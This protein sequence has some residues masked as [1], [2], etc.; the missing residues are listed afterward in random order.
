[1]ELLWILLIMLSMSPFCSG[2]GPS[3]NVKIGGKLPI[4]G[5]VEAVCTAHGQKG[6]AVN[7]Y[8]VKPNKTK[9]DIIK[10]KDGLTEEMHTVERKIDELNSTF[11]KESVKLTIKYNVMSVLTYFKCKLKNAQFLICQGSYKCVADFS[12]PKR[13]VYMENVAI[14]NI[15]GAIRMPPRSIISKMTTESTTGKII[16]VQ[17]GGG[18]VPILRYKVMYKQRADHRLTF[19]QGPVVKSDSRNAVIADLKPYTEYNIYV[20]SVLPD[21]LEVSVGTGTNLIRSPMYRVQT[22]VDGPEI[23]PKNMKAERVGPTYIYLTWQLP[24]PASWNGP[25]DGLFVT[26]KRIKHGEL[27]ISGEKTVESTVTGH[28]TK[29]N[30]LN[31][32]PWSTYL[33]TACGFNQKKTGSQIMYGKTG[34]LTVDTHLAKPATPPLNLDQV[35]VDSNSATMKWEAPELSNANG[36]IDGYILR[37]TRRE[38]GYRRVDE[39][40]MEIKIPRNQSRNYTLKGLLP[41]STYHVVVIAY[42]MFNGRQLQSKPSHAL[43]VQTLESKP[44][45]PPREIVIE[46]TEAKS[47]LLSWQPPRAKEN[48]NGPIDGYIVIYKRTKLG[49]QVLD[50]VAKFEKIV[51]K[52]GNANFNLSGLLPWS[53]YDIQIAAFNLETKRKTIQIGKRL[54]SRFSEP[55]PVL[56]RVSEPEISSFQFKALRTSSTRASLSWKRPPLESANGPIGGYLVNYKR[57][58]SGDMKLS[59]KKLALQ[60]VVSGQRET[61]RLDQLKPWSTYKVEIISFNILNGKQLYSKANEQLIVRTEVDKPSKSPEISATV[62]TGVRFIEVRW[63]AL[64]RDDQNGPLDGYEVFYQRTSYGSKKI[65]DVKPKK[66][67]VPGS[68]TAYKLS[69]LVPWSTYNIWVLAYNLKNNEKLAS[70]VGKILV[71]KTRTGRPAV[72]PSSVEIPS[73][74][75]KSITISWKRPKDEEL[76]GELTGFLIRANGSA[77]TNT[78]SE[79]TKR[80]VVDVTSQVHNVSKDTTSFTLENLRPAT[81]YSLEVAA[82]T[83][84]GLGPYS[85]PVYKTT[86]E[87]APSAP[88]EPRVLSSDS[89]LPVRVAWKTPS[90]TNGKITAYVIELFKVGP[91]ETTTFLSSGPRTAY[92]VSNID[93]EY[94]YLFRVQAKT[95]RPGKW[96]EWTVLYVPDPSITAASRSDDGTSY[97]VPAVVG[98]V[99]LFCFLIAF[100]MYKRM[101]A[102]EYN[103]SKSDERQRLPHVDVEMGSVKENRGTDADEILG[104]D[105]DDI[106]AP[107]LKEKQFTDEDEQTNNSDIKKSPCNT[108]PPSSLPCDP[109]HPP[110]TVER[111]QA[112]V[113]DLM[114]DGGAKLKG[115]YQDFKVGQIYTWDIAMKPNNKSKNRYANIVAYD[116]SR[117]ILKPVPGDRNGSDYINASYIDGYHYP[118]EYI[119]TQGP[120]EETVVDFWRM[121]WQER[122]S[123]IVCLT[124]LIELGKAKCSQYWPS[125]GEERYGDITVSLVSTD[126][127]AH[128]L[129][130]TMDIRHDQSDEVRQISQFHFLSW[131]D[132]GTPSRPTALLSLRQRVRHFYDGKTPMILHC[133]AGVG[134]T[135]CFILI[136][137]MLE[138]SAREGTIDVYNCLQ[139]L[140][141]RR[142]NMVQ[143]EDQY[144]FVHTALLEAVLCGKTEMLAKDVPLMLKKFKNVGKDD[145][146]THYEREF[147]KLLGTCPDLKWEDCTTALQPENI[148]K[149]RSLEIIARDND[150]VILSP[151]PRHSSANYIN[152]VCVDGYKERNAFILTEA[153][154]E[155]TV[156]TLWKMVYEKECR[157]IIVLYGLKESTETYPCFWPADE[158]EHATETYGGF[159]V[160]M[161]SEQMDGDIYSKRLC[162]TCADE[163]N[164]EREVQLLQYVA[165]PYHDLPDSKRD[166]LALIS[167]AEESQRR[168]GSSPILVIC[169]DGAS[170]CGTLCSIYN[171]IERVKVEQIIDV[172]QVVRSIKIVRP[173]SVATVEQMEY[174]YEMVL[175]YL[176][177][178]DNYININFN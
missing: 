22:D 82:A 104:D 140:R 130:R 32:K 110:I 144:L 56:T 8:V 57:I 1:M 71:A 41:W 73:W 43:V 21:Q 37:Y 168:L 117:V 160:E 116:H 178:F 91:N 17:P 5:M 147:K 135:G 154:M 66:E 139:Y 31:L 120:T 125:I 97:L 134:R 157:T 63:K 72:S 68:V 7:W 177:S 163:P 78:S 85:K 4:R 90:Q 167:R 132:H 84:A 50:K 36:P 67:G 141:S 152:A 9:D 74:S 95:V 81:K 98:G 61:Y 24:P 145:G 79:R 122:S 86:G 14:V 149:S 58:K 34:N 25:L 92:N 153:P 170:R 59:D 158:G 16:W 30:A 175:E 55:F 87:D 109:A 121:I 40:A 10:L 38:V 165:W 26:Y 47:V 137:E 45:K 155:S 6:M 111:F 44:E 114:A 70:P 20:A 138:R 93:M 124:N 146:L 126:K 27:L 75:A 148:K 102:N 46:K 64:T 49:G 113:L 173:H 108:P 143:T 39:K 151:D 128:Y 83:N 159:S 174:I 100:I 23:E 94:K 69:E 60:R 80:E 77:N 166:I 162:L 42:N 164:Y 29:F 99:L 13:G 133:S 15:D 52:G 101:N 119:A 12:P 176:N 53:T 115:E 106:E 2:S 169:S 62:K 96:S 107:L 33:L 18:D 35:I 129:I 76:N 28:I 131:P 105:I 123:V 156:P 11:I 118:E 161:I 150:R 112:H 127:T 65:T 54:I 88:L 19:T 51:A 103:L 142:I 3:V 48:A 172:F 171:C 89:P 136:D